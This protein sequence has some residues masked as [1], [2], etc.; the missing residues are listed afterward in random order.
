MTAGAS[1]RSGA[2]ARRQKGQTVIPHPLFL[3]AILL[4]RPAAPKPNILCW[5]FCR[6]VVKSSSDTGGHE[7]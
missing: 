2:P 4:G 1:R 5:Y 6:R 7:E 3:Y